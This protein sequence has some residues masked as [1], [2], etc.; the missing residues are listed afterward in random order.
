[1][2][3]DI[4]SSSFW[5]ACAW[6][7]S[8]FSLNFLFEVKDV[9]TSTNFSSVLGDH[10]ME[11][12]LLLCCLCGISKTNKNVNCVAEPQELQALLDILSISNSSWI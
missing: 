4:L 3:N 10:L 6:H 7:H 5:N 12:K 1:M 11:C 2:C 9:K 8:T